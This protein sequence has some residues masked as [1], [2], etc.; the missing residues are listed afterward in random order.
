MRESEAICHPK[1]KDLFQDSN[2]FSNRLFLGQ[3]LIMAMGKTFI[4]ILTSTLTKLKR[5]EIK[6]LDLFLHRMKLHQ[7]NTIRKA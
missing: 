7:D 2:T 3:H 6:L 5:K 1:D 4:D